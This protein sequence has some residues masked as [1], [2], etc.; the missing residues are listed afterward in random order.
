[1]P[2]EIFKDIRDAS[3]RKKHTVRHDLYDEAEFK[4]MENRS[5]RLQEYCNPESGVVE[6]NPTVPA[7]MQDAFNSFYKY[8]PTFEDNDKIRPSF[9][10]NKQIIERMMKTEDYRNLREITKLD[11][12]NSAM[13]AAFF[14]ESFIEQLQKFKPNQ[15]RQTRK[16]QELEEQL[17]QEINAMKDAESAENT[18]KKK[19]HQDNIEKIEQEMQAMQQKSERIPQLAVS[20]AMNDATQQTSEA[21]DAIKS[22]GWGKGEGTIKQEDPE[23]RMELAEKLMENKKL[24]EIIKTLGRMKDI[25]KSE[26]EA[27]VRRHTNEIVSIEMGSNISNMLASE[28]ALLSD[29]E[30]EMHFYRKYAEDG[31][32]Q[33]EKERKE[34]KGKGGIIVCLDLSGSMSGTK[35]IWAKAVALAAL[36]IA[37]RDKR[38][39]RLI[40]FAKEVHNVRQYSRGNIP[41]IDDVLEIAG[42]NYGGGTQFRPPLLEAMET[43]RKDGYETKNDILFVTDGQC[44][45]NDDFISLFQRFKDEKDCRMTGVQIGSW[46]YKDILERLSDNVV[47]V[48][49]FTGEEAGGRAREIFSGMAR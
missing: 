47:P 40:S 31:L 32:M 27:K 18:E 10:T 17:M 38:P 35:E 34:H 6:N 26:R 21:A 20:R 3:K 16:M 43:I 30:T 14:A 41:E 5:G 45:V 39:Y 19:E 15:G 44:D 13:G 12:C 2:R 1:M 24:F 7:L 28:I 42:E 37:V 4:D 23:T 36:E 46:G 9:Q 11:K 49:E 29:D 25:A 48:K 33:Y 8:S 22:F